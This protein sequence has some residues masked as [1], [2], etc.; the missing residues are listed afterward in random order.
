MADVSLTAFRDF[1]DYWEQRRPL[2]EEPFQRT[3]S[4][5][6]D[7]IPL[8][9]S[10]SLRATLEAGK[11]IRGCL[12]CL[13]SEALGGDLT[14]AAP[15]AVAIELVQAATLIHDDFVDQDTMR[16]NRPAVWT[17]EGPR[18]AVLIGD[19]LFATAIQMMS[20]LSR[21]DGLTISRAIAQVSQGALR[22]PLDPLTLSQ[23]MAADRVGGG[24]YEKIIRLKTGIL[25]GAA[26]HLGAIAAGADQKYRQKAFRFGV[27]IG[28]A[29][30]IADDLSEVQQQLSRSGHYAEAGP[31]PGPRRSLFCERD[32]PFPERDPDRKIHDLGSAG[33]GRTGYGRRPNAGGHPRPPGKGAG[34]N[35]RRLFRKP[36]E[37]T[38]QES[39]EGYHPDVQ[40]LPGK[41]P[42]FRAVTMAEVPQVSEVWV[43]S[44]K[45][46]FCSER[47][48]SR[49]H[50]VSRRNPGKLIKNRL[51][52]G[53]FPGPQGLQESKI[54]LPDPGQDR[55]RGIGKIMHD[56]DPPHPEQIFVM[57]DQAFEVGIFGQIGGGNA[58]ET[59]IR[60]DLLSPCP[61]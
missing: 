34:G 41:F 32:S 15:R 58:V 52:L 10:V 48:S 59:Q 23:E 44:E 16:G 37:R 35:G 5:L 12:S 28:E 1:R 19:V 17:I 31:G 13:I 40:R 47:S 25:F 18:R 14:S 46:F 43:I 57:A 20:E 55:V 24:V 26:C 50:W 7:G 45:P 36:L 39:P 56:Q 4:G 27:Q 21:E 60:T 42:S 29:Y 49:V 38:G 8:R 53:I 9:D 6:L 51:P 3:L 33:P 61:R 54:K 30:Q 11:K 22:E 2:V